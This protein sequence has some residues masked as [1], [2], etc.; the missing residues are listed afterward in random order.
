MDGEDSRSA[1]QRA[2]R[3]ARHPGGE[4]VDERDLTFDAAPQALHRTLGAA[5]GSGVFQDHDL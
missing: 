1:A 2:H 5:A 4:P 3:A